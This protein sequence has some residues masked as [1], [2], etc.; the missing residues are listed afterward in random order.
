MTAPVLCELLDEDC[1]PDAHVD[2]T[3]VLPFEA[4]QKSR[5]RLCL[6]SGRVAGL[7]LPRGSVVRDGALL[8]GDGIVVRVVAAHE[9]VSV[10]TGDAAQLLRAAYHLGNRHV[11]V[12]LGEQALVYLHD[13]VLDEMVR[14]LG[15]LVS[16]AEYA[17][18][19]ESGAYSSTA[20]GVHSHHHQHD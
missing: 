5:Q 14:G 17:F 20:P 3:V 19:P 15:L 4:R 8:G 7:N 11:A 13:H 10:A 1:G 12:E 16:V 9:S 6:A 18:E 2:D